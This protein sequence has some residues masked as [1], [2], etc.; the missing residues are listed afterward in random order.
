M[1]L[2]AS[3]TVVALFASVLSAAPAPQAPSAPQA[4]QAP[5]VPQTPQPVFRAGIELIS[6]V[7]NALD[8]YG[9]LV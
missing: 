2:T 5:S 6:V 1:R 3:A 4:P 9:R 8:S 7:I